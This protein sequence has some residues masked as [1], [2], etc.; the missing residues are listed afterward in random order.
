MN[1]ELIE[2]INIFNKKIEELE[3]KIKIDCDGSYQDILLKIL[4]EIKK[5]EKRNYYDIKISSLEKLGNI[6][7]DIFGEEIQ[8]K[9]WSKCENILHKDSV[10]LLKYLEDVIYFIFDYS[11][12][13]KLSKEKIK[14][15]ILKEWKKQRKIIDEEEYIIEFFKIK[16]ILEERISKSLDKI[17]EKKFYDLFFKL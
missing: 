2:I 9:F 5:N 16:K 3:K 15:E 17:G 1:K 12:K 14:E 7:N 6:I 4:S 10:K 13:I 11:Y 8:D